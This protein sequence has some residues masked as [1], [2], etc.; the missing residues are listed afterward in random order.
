MT[1][2]HNIFIDTGKVRFDLT[3]D[4]NITVITGDS[5]IGK[6]YLCDTIRIYI[7]LGK[8]SGIDIKTDVQLAVGA[9]TL[10]DAVRQ[11]KNNVGMVIFYDEDLK[12]VTTKEFAEAVKGTDNY[13][14]IIYREAIKN[15]PY[16]IKAVKSLV[17]KKTNGIFVSELIELFNLHKLEKVFKPELLITEDKKSGFEF[18]DL[19]SNCEC[20]SADGNAN[21]RNKLKSCKKYSNILVVVDGAAFGPLYME[22]MDYI[23]ATNQKVVVWAPESFEYLILQSGV[24]RHEKLDYFLQETYNYADSCKY[25]SWEQYYT[26]LLNELCQYNN[27]GNY[28]KSTLS[29]YFKRKPIVDKIIEKF[30]KEIIL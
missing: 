22:L 6:T 14:V 28:S 25:E 20:D 19:I 4:R 26:A 12:Y 11:L 21:I 8:S 27:I 18:F 9:D 29:T 23:D 7:R 10:E 17:T 15:L 2:K 13:I 16:A 30:P 5:A 1:G 24:V 3:V